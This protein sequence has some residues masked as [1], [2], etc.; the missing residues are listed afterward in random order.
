MEAFF[1]AM[2]DITIG[3]LHL[4]SRVSSLVEK[5]GHRLLFA[6]GVR[7]SSAS[8]KGPKVCLGD[9]VGKDS[10]VTDEAMIKVAQ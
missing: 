8:K 6:K 10:F 2:V 7:C 5:C 1:N 9:P 3:V 4:S